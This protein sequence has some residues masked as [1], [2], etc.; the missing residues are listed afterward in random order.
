LFVSNYQLVVL[1]VLNENRYLI[2]TLKSSSETKAAENPCGIHSIEINPS[3]TLLA[4]GGDN[5]NDVAIYRLPTLDPV[6]VGEVS[7]K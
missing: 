2:P 6:C 4:T 1:D 3:R 7:L 5:P